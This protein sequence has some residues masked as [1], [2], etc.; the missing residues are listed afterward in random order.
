MQTETDELESVYKELLLL[1]NEMKV[2]KKNQV[3]S[4]ALHEDYEIIHLSPRN[5]NDGGSDISQ[6]VLM[7]VQEDHGLAEGD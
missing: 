4:S 7:N 2:I 5:R 3:P 6:E 1:C